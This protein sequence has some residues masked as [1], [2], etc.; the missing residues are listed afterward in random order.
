MWSAATSL[1]TSLSVV[2][3]LLP[4]TLHGDGG[5]GVGYQARDIAMSGDTLIM[6]RSRINDNRVLFYKMN[7]E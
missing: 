1:I 2:G 6:L 4:Q 5:T 3:D 7:Y